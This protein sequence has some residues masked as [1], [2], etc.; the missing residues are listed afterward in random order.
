MQTPFAND[1][2]PGPKSLSKAGENQEF[3]SGN[4]NH[5]INHVQFGST[6]ILGH[7]D[8]TELKYPNH[9]IYQSRKCQVFC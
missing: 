8:E 3:L 5:E 6:S 2:T 7:V 9:I 4:V 1:K